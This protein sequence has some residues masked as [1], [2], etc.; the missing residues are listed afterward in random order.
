MRNDLPKVRRP[1]RRVLARHGVRDKSRKPPVSEAGTV[2]NSSLQRNDV[3]LPVLFKV[4]TEGHVKSHGAQFSCSSWQESPKAAGIAKT[5]DRLEKGIALQ[6]FGRIG[7]RQIMPLAV[8]Q[9]SCQLFERAG[10][11]QD[12]ADAGLAND[13]SATPGSRWGFVTWSNDVR[14]GS[15]D[16]SQNLRSPS[17]LVIP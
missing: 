1:G 11:E 17:E 14:D 8:G 6:Y 3:I 5:Q 9:P 12:I 15:Q 10:A 16:R 7:C 4:T 13:Q 2:G